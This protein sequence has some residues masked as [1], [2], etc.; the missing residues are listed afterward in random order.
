[1]LCGANLAVVTHIMY[2]Y[3]SF[4]CVKCVHKWGLAQSPCC[5]FGQRQT[6]NHIV[7]MCPLTKFDGGLNLLR[8]ADNDS[9]MAGIYSDCSTCEIIIIVYCTAWKCNS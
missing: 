2:R 9:H 5:D 4:R 1:M 7:A 6:M 3:C 8:E